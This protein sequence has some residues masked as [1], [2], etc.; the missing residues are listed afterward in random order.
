MIISAEK[1][2]L[3]YGTARILNDVSLR[4]DNKEFVGLIGPNG[5]GKSTLLKCIY[6]VLKQDEGCVM[7]DPC[8]GVDAADPLPD[9]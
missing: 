5:S 8:Q 3:S 6:R 9:P 2:H 1:I 7:G 4:A